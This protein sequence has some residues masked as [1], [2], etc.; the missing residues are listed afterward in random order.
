VPEGRGVRS[1]LRIAIGL[2]IVLGGVWTC[3]YTLDGT[4]SFRERGCREIGSTT[5]GEKVWSCPDDGGGE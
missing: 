1:F 3:S 5:R 2:F 4:R